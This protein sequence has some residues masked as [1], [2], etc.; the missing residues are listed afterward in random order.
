ME[1][2]DLEKQWI[3]AID[4]YAS[5][6]E[7]ERLDEIFS[8]AQIE[9]YE[10]TM[11]NYSL[12]SSFGEFLHK[13]RSQGFAFLGTGKAPWIHG[14][15]DAAIVFEDVDTFQKYWYHTNFYIIEWWQEQVALYLGKDLG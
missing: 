15:R 2:N 9:S 8:S 10:H 3:K 14:E 7:I 5:K 11:D 12:D 4:K 1:F 6:E 13:L